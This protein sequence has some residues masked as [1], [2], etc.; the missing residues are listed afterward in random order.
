MHYAEVI[1]KYSFSRNILDNLQ[2]ASE[3]WGRTAP[4]PPVGPE[5]AAEPKAQKRL[6]K[7]RGKRRS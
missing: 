7:M 2:A 5:P 3:L 4:Q 1:F 6:L